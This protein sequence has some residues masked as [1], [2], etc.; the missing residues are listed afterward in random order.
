MSVSRILGLSFLL[1]WTLAAQAPD[2]PS[3]EIASVK[4]SQLQLGPDYNN[5]F[6]FSPSGIAARNATLRRLV[7]EAFRVQMKQVSG[8]NWL[9]ENEYDV[10]ARTGDPAGRETLE[11]MLRTL[12]AERFAL[13]QHVESRPMRVYELVADKGGLKIIPAQ[14]AETMAGPGFRFHGDMRQFANF[15][16]VQLSIPILDDPN[17]PG[18]AGGAAMLVLDKTGL[19]DVYDFRAEV[20][21]EL[22]VDSFS[23][24][25][26]LLRE[27]LGLKL[28]SHR[29]PVE[30]VVVDR[31]AR[32]PASN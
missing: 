31:A 27:Q 13:K 28:E 21:P 25:Q 20:S 16:A 10:E 9:D 24:W 8:P 2:T 4:A 26:R 11:R 30:I 22:G 6:T 17:Q 18:R 12:L 23:L 3:F 15:L 14:S 32:T 5:Q 7:S 29:R 1:S 19:P